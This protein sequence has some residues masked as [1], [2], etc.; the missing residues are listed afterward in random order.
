VHRDATLTLI[1]DQLGPR[2]ADRAAAVDRDAA[3]PYANYEELRDAGLLG[4]CI[5][6]AYGGLGASFADYMQID[7]AI[8]EYCATT[9]VTFNMHCQTLLWT[10][11]IADDLD[12]PPP[13]RATLDERRTR[14]YRGVLDH[15]ELYAQP[16]SEGVARAATAGVATTARIVAGGFLVSGRKIFASLAGAADHY[17]I[18]CQTPGEHRIRFLAVRADNPGVTITGDWDVLGL[19]GTDSRTLVFHD[20]FVAA[21]DELL[22]AGVYDQLAAR[23]PA[24]YMTLSAT[25]VGLIRAITDYTRR[26]LASD[27]PPGV[28]AR[29]D[30]PQK[31]AGWAQL[32]IL[33][34]R[35]LVLWER[36][37]A[38]A[39]VDPAPQTLTR[40]YAAHYTV[41]ESV[42]EIAALAIRVC[43]GQSISRSMPL[44]RH[45]RDARCGALML[46]WSAEALLDRLGRVGIS[47]DA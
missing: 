45:Y 44:E 2:F 39:A 19:R 42:V 46:P 13:E 14:L 11:G 26:Y 29:R 21:G 22:P 38:D 47:P 10:G 6:E 15:G 3:F 4:L 27:P 17:S 8:G 5:P 24:V 31:Q 23:W 41:M 18:T 12:L 20:A 7:A 33:R 34:E 35:A 32:L 40:A 43:G 28:T 37:V 36:A 30:A 9:A 1:H 16:L 25:F